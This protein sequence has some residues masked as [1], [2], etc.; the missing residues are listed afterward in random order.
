MK[1]KYCQKKSGTIA[2]IGP[3][4]D[5]KENMAGTWV[6]TWINPF[7]IAGI[8]EA[9]NGTNVLYA[10]GSN[11]DYDASFEEKATMFGKPCIVMIELLQ[12]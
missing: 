5:A 10:K 9:G 12:N 3:L 7:L 4:A 1:S 11:L 6:Q 8:K 2:V